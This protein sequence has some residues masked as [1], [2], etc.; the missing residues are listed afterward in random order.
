MIAVCKT[1]V[2]LAFDNCWAKV[3]VAVDDEEVRLTTKVFQRV[4]VRTGEIRDGLARF[5]GSSK[6]NAEVCQT[7]LEKWREKGFGRDPIGRDIHTRI[8]V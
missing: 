2:F 6:A 3:L 7:V 5:E 8:V 1:D 4:S